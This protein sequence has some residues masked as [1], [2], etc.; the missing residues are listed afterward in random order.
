[1]NQ[2]VILTICAYMND[3]IALIFHEEVSGME[4]CDYYTAELLP[5]WC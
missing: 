3:V 4:M 1:M 2:V 5:L